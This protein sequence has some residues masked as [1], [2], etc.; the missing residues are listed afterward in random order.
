[1]LLPIKKPRQGAM[2][3]RRLAVRV[4]KSIQSQEAIEVND[5]GLHLLTP[6][7]LKIEHLHQKFL[8]FFFFDP[9]ASSTTWKHSEAL[10]FFE[11]KL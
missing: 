10:S 11:I 7:W 9:E 3:S 1:M 4:A 8:R 2:S 6:E 5:G